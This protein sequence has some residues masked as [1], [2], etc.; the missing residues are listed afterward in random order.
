[1]VIGGA[2][3]MIA[4]GRRTPCWETWRGPREGVETTVVTLCTLCDRDFLGRCWYFAADRFWPSFYYSP[5]KDGKNLWLFM[6]LACMV[7]YA[8][9]VFLAFNGIRR[10]SYA[11]A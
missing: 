4:I 3:G 1:M 10:T 7:V 5:I 9:G 8:I 2:L 11:M 6:Q